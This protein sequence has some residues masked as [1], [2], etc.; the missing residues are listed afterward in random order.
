MARTDMVLEHQDKGTCDSDTLGPPTLISAPCCD[1]AHVCTA[2]ACHVIRPLCGHPYKCRSAAR[3]FWYM[4]TIRFPF[5]LNGCNV[6]SSSSPWSGQ[7]DCPS[8]PTNL[9]LKNPALVARFTANCQGLARP[10]S[11]T[12]YT[13]EF[14]TRQ[15]FLALRYFRLVASSLLL[16]ARLLG[17]GQP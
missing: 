16:L 13:W 14:P 5:G 1:A 11:Y 9:K 8:L 4:R 17:L 10:E 12:I 7:C 2:I 6:A 15:S 3:G